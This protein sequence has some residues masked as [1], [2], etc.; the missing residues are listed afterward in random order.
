MNGLVF[1][2]QIHGSALLLRRVNA[3]Q[4][5]PLIHGFAF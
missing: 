2:A 3:A 5:R 1:S 4:L